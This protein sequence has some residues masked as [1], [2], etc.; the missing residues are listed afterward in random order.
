[1]LLVL[2]LAVIS[3]EKDPTVTV[4][5]AK[6]ISAQYLA[7]VWRGKKKKITNKM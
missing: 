7:M 2:K 6:K 1:M 5:T 3:Q 4:N